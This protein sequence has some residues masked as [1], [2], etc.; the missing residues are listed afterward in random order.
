M[1]QKSLM[2]SESAA[3][4]FS[5]TIFM[6]MVEYVRYRFYASTVEYIY[7]LVV[8]LIVV[9][10]LESAAIQFF[11]TISMSTKEYVRL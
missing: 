11:S 2:I 8:E 1:T 10:I 7:V 5:S 6:S 3:T 9:T 4:Q